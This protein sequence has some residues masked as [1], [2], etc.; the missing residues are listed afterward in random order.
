MI[1]QRYADLFAQGLYFTRRIYCIYPD[2][3]V[4]NIPLSAL[5]SSETDP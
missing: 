2:I 3:F 1:E 5:S 4:A